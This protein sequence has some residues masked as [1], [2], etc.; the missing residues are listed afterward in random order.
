MAVP[1][2]VEQDRRFEPLLRGVSQYWNDLAV[3]A[4]RVGLPMEAE[5]FSEQATV[6]RSIAQAVGQA[7]LF[8]GQPVPSLTDIDEVLE[9]VEGILY[10]QTVAIG[11]NLSR[12]EIPVSYNVLLVMRRLY[13][14]KRVIMSYVSYPDTRS[15]EPFMGNSEEEIGIF[16]G[17][18]ARL[19]KLL[20]TKPVEE[21][22]AEDLERLRSEGAESGPAN[23]FQL[24][25]KARFSANHN[26]VMVEEH[27]LLPGSESSEDGK[28]VIVRIGKKG[29]PV[30]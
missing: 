10:G 1:N 7:A 20:D 18:L 26:L 5:L 2:E 15:D 21:F 23:I 17:T 22:S 25:Q 27:E 16:E 13:F 29:D 6:N 12:F 14:G 9:S 3:D 11:H 28:K 8:N 30:I 24:I 19:H 4:T